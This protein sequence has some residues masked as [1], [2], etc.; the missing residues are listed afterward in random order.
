MS[1]PLWTLCMLSAS[2]AAVLYLTCSE[3]CGRLKMYLLPYR[4]EWSVR[5]GGSPG[6]PVARGVPRSLPAGLSRVCL[7]SSLHLPALSY[8]ACSLQD[9]WGKGPCFCCVCTPA[10]TTELWSV[11]MVP[12]WCKATSSEKMVTD[13]KFT[14][15]FVAFRYYF[16]TT[17]A[18][19]STSC[20]WCLGV[21]RWIQRNDFQFHVLLHYR[22]VFDLV[23]GIGAATVS[24]PWLSAPKCLFRTKPSDGHFKGVLLCFCHV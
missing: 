22:H 12:R 24:T 17:C 23:S 8:G 9:N 7:C 6:V 5:W 21:M 2:T 20:M 1:L 19:F 10:C 13:F 14:L 18:D 3:L 15:V 11:S 4:A 16:K